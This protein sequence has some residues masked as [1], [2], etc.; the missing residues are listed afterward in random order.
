MTA[1]DIATARHWAAFYKLRGWQALPSRP[2]DKRPMLKYA[3]YWYTQ[4]PDDLFD[5]FPT[6]NIQL[7]L[8]RHWRLMAID[9]DG[10]EARDRWKQLGQHPQTWQTHSGGDG[11]HIWFRLP[12]ELHKPLPKAFLWKGDGKHN[13]IERLCDHSLLMVPPSIH[14]KTGQRYRFTSPATSPE[15]LPLPALAPSWVLRLAPVQ[16][17]RAEFTPVVPVAR[18]RAP[19][20]WRGPVDIPA[21]VRAW[22]VRLA[23]KP[24]P[25]GWVPCHAIDREDQHPSAAIHQQTGRYVDLGSGT[26]LSLYDLAVRLNVYP[27]TREAFREIGPT[28]A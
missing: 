10:P 9:L 16:L 12:A 22:G 4:A 27:T 23:G 1:T 24:S 19:R 26:R 13:A 7:M 20:P 11:L 8:G 6:S 5:S 14:P 3:D 21:M 2:D 15:R 17:T 25:R 18:E 28:H